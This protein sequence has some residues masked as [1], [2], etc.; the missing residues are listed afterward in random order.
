MIR[1]TNLHQFASVLDG[2][3]EVVD[4]LSERVPT[5]VVIVHFAGLR[6]A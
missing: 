1:S 3:T 6:G 4:L 2:E 5:T